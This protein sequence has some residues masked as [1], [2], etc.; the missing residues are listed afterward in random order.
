M[1]DEVLTVS[2]PA[3]SANLGPGFDTLAL[4]LDLANEVRITRRP[5]PARGAGE[6]E[7]A[8]EVPDGRG[9]TWSAAALAA[10]L[11]D[12]DGLLVE[13]RNRIPLGRGLGSSAAAAC[14]GLVAANAL[15]GLRWSPDDVLRPRRGARGPRR[16]RRR[17]P[18]RRHRGRRPRPERGAHR[19][20]GR[21]GLRHRRARGPGL[22][23]G[24]APVPARARPARRG[25]RD[26][27]RGPWAWRWPCARGGSRT[28]RR[29]WWTRLHEPCRA[30][31]GAGP[32]GAPRP[33]RRPEGCLGRDDLRL[34]AVGAAVVPRRERGA[35]RRR[36]PGGARRGGG[37]GR[38]ARGA[39]A[40]RAGSA[41][42]G[43]SRRRGWPRRW[44][45]RRARLGARRRRARLLPG[46]PGGDRQRHAGLL[47]RR[48]R[49]LRHR[50]RRGPRRP[51]GRAGRRRGRGGRRVAALRRRPP[52]RR[53]RSTASSPVIERLVAR[54]RRAG[55]R[56]HLQGAGG[57]GGHR[58]RGEHPQRPD[59]PPR[60]ANGAA[61][62]RRAA[63]GWS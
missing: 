56:R 28:C 3:S 17:V 38:G 53:S 7:G 27:V 9:R 61:W 25:R 31:P 18:A 46:P 43:A 22:H 35:G 29:S 36:G 11:P 4:A 32:R 63:W 33:G 8:G 54:G 58:R 50:A 21:P 48:G 47:H 1:A 14:A 26:G 57:R 45:E 42:A 55:G 34:G 12:L 59:R 24:G 52:P 60:P 20:P 62:P 6:G 10:G 41:P 40:R 2:A 39:R 49:A 15:G 23:P 16:Q 37:G 51:P 13:C 30:P 5:G 44:D 19:P